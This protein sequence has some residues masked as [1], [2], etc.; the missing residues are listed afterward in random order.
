MHLMPGHPSLAV[1][2]DYGSPEGWLAELAILSVPCP[3]CGAGVG[4]RCHGMSDGTLFA[5]YLHVARFEAAKLRDHDANQ[6][7]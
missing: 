3:E 1:V 5:C 6:I 7:P 4:S 2:N